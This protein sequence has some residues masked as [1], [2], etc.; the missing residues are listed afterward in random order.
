MYICTMEYYSV[1]GHLVCFHVLA[2]VNS[3]SV[4]T[5]VHVSL[6]IIVFSEYICPGVRLAISVS[7]MCTPY[8]EQIKSS[9][10]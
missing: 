7:P 4:K 5:E 6:Q 10:K 8:T 1:N 3:A 9:Y 2:G